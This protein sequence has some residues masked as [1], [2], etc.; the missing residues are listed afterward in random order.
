MTLVI[1]PACRALCAATY[2]RDLRG[3]SDS[4][5]LGLF[6]AGVSELVYRIEHDSRQ[7]PQALARLAG[8]L[9]AID[10]PAPKIAGEPSSGDAEA[11]AEGRPPSPASSSGTD[12][13]PVLDAGPGAVPG[14]A[15]SPTPSHGA[16]EPAS[17]AAPGAA[18]VVAGGLPLSMA[19]PPAAVQGEPE[20][21]GSDAA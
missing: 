9:D 2:A 1:D 18:R 5:L 16:S 11:V 20:S 10:N 19:S 4:F 17:D 7:A 6:E 15:C 13:S 14:P 3:R 12:P 21:L 8:L